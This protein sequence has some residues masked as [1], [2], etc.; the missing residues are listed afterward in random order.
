VTPIN[1]TN[2]RRHYI[3]APKPAASLERPTGASNKSPSTCGFGSA[4]VMRRSFVRLIGVTPNQY[5]ELRTT[6]PSVVSNWKIAGGSSTTLPQSQGFGS[7]PIWLLTADRIRC[8][9]PDIVRSFALR[10]APRGIGSAPTRLPKHGRAEHRSVAD[11]V[12]QLRHADALGGFLHNV[13][14][15]P[16]PSC[17]LPMSFQLC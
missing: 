3:S 16:S 15:P 13:A 10:Y 8:L 12:A 17:H 5:R 4:D 11:R 9:Q 6:S 14:K 1:R 2:E 7:I